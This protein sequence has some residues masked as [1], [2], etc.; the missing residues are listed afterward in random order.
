MPE[1]TSQ[2]TR[3]RRV[4][5]IGAGPAGA[6]ATDALVKEQAFD[7]V[8]VFE[9]KI[10]PGGTWVYDPTSLPSR[11]TIPSVP[12]LLDGTAD[13][14]VEL[15]A[16]L[17]YGFPI[18]TV[19]STATNDASQR[20]AHT[21]VHDGLHSNLPP[22]TMSFTQEPIPAV[23]SEYTS[24][25]YGSNAPFRHREVIRQWVEGIFDAGNHRP[26]ISFGTY[27]ERAEKRGTEWVLT[28]R[29]ETTRDNKKVNKWW[30]ETFDAVVVASGHY[31]LP[32]LPPIPGLADYDA[33]FPGRI[34]HSKHYRSVDDF[35]NKRVIVVGGSVSAFDAL[36]A[37]RKVAQ[38]PVIASL[39]QPLPAFGWPAFTHPHVDIRSPIVLFHPDS[40]QIDFAD[41]SSVQDVDV[42]LFATGYDFSFPFLEGAGIQIKNRRIQGLYQHVF[43]MDDPTL[44]FIGMV[45]GGLTFRVFEW[46]SVAAARVF[47]GRATLPSPTEMRQWETDT[48]TEKG[49]GT[50][51]FNIA[52]DFTGYFD[53]LRSLAGEPAQGTT[54]RV[55]PPFEQNW[56]DAFNEVI[57]MRL[58]W[59]D[60]ER[61]KAEAEEA[62]ESEKAEKMLIKTKRI[63]GVHRPLENR[64]HL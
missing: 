51:F 14:P 17:S 26:L 63:S 46:Q 31:S 37:V 64:V 45:A 16:A 11:P 59:W 57:S 54:G 48:A 4:A 36:H 5:V 1:P 24:T 20:Y 39:R 38:R 6:I 10:V 58:A 2:P 30:Q 25:Q 56:A 53:G 3:R 9:R 18:E 43:H 47:A 42:I 19:H 61:R 33:A 62:E 50:R 60:R 12:A 21:G 23:I 41:G 49:D 7:V 15:P 34:R 28:L 29:Q 8:R 27:V 52:P 13:R 40:G 55:L 22:Q 44:A 32:Y 35:A